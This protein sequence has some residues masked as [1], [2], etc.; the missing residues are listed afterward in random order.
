MEKSLK[1]SVLL[2]TY[3]HEKYIK[4]AIESV[5]M[6][7]LDYDYEIVIADDCSTDSTLEIINKYKEL[8]PEKINILKD[9]KNLG[10][11]Q[12]YKRGFEACKGEYIA[13]L[14]GDDYW[15]SKLKLKKHIDFL[16]EHGECALSFNRFVVFD[17]IDKRQNVQPWPL[18]N[19]FQL[20]TVTD[21][22]K[23]NF[24]GN[25]STCVYRANLLKMIDKSVYDLVVYDWM[26]NILVAQ[27]GLIGY[28]GEVMSVYRL[29]PNGVW[30][31]KS[32]LDKLQSTIKS[33]DE[34]DNY[35]QLRY[36]DEFCEHKNRILNR[37]NKLINPDGTCKKASRKEKIKKYIPPI[38]IY[39]I[40]IIMPPK[41][42][43][44]LKK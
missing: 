13:I 41:I 8:Y 29:H 3:N 1:L 4:E 39:L 24:I 35:L 12:N 9:E 43:E 44:M 25:F 26:I 10:I 31:R 37:V 34:Y 15:T 32:E 30:T 28:L 38:L 5:L 23:D 14:E 18:N 22:V 27:N 19:A 33:I 17:I 36:T 20:I 42:I 40:K 21:L 7:K 2:V 6:Q 11:T 16:D